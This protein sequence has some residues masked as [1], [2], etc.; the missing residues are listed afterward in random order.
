MDDDVITGELPLWTCNTQTSG[1]ISLSVKINHKDIS[2]DRGKGSFY[3]LLHAVPL[4]YTSD[5]AVPIRIEMASI[6]HHAFRDPAQIGKAVVTLSSGFPEW[7]GGLRG[8]I[9][10]RVPRGRLPLPRVRASSA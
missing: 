1:R 2:P 6:P 9:T 5:D 8:H 4:C 3:E 10:S 7:S